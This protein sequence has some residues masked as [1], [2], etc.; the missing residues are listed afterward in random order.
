[1]RIRQSLNGIEYPV[2]TDTGPGRGWEIPVKLWI[3]Y[4]EAVRQLES[5]HE[6]IEEAY[7]KGFKQREGSTSE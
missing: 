5:V 1:M 3:R 2:Y 6:E 4:K 7:S